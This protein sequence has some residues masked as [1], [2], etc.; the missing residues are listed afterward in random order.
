MADIVTLI[1]QMV[2]DGIGRRLATNPR[3]QFGTP[4]QPLLGAT[5]LP[6]Q[7]REQN[8]YRE[9]SIRYRTVIANSS[10]RYSPPQKKGSALIGTMR[11]ELA[12]SDV[13]SELTAQQYDYL[14]KLLNTGGDMQAL[15]NLIRFLDTGV[16][17]PLA[18]LREQ[19]R[20]QAIENAQVIRLGDNNYNET[21]DYPNPIG[22]R[23]T[24][25]GTWSSNS[26]D[27]MDD[28]YAA[29]EFL[30]AKGYTVN[31]I[32]GRTKVRNI[33]KKN[34]KIVA[35][36]SKVTIVGG[37]ITNT[38]GRVSNAELDDIFGDD[39]LPPFE[40]YDGHYLTQTGMGYFIGDGSLIMAC[41]TGRS[42]DI[43][44]GDGEVLSLP[45]TLGY[46]AI[47]V[48]TGQAQP[49]IRTVLKDYGDEKPP[50]IEA[51]GWQT[52]LPILQDPEAL[53]VLKGIA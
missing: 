32:I 22:H 15:A 20:W 28:I 7:N 46:T 23:P 29:V 45:N 6:E 34:T 40:T 24:V 21:V 1:N 53:M 17:Q 11:V 47:G 16:I 3:V 37:N 5:L 35:R 26:Y 8:D 13:A 27:P 52:S 41:T 33:L 38:T 4:S 48:P 25:G 14:I 9:D 42:Q 31:R 51:S 50:R 36:G 12:E 10:T 39:N 49:G 19:Q 30:A 43:D 44:L 18:L 2:S